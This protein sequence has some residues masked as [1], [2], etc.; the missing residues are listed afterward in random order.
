MVRNFKIC[1][2]SPNTI[3][4]LAQWYVDDVVKLHGALISVFFYRGIE[5]SSHLWRVAQSSLDTKM[6]LS[7]AF[8]PQT[9]KQTERVNQVLEDMLRA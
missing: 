1:I 4:E 8:H 9:D 3:E 2:F 7:T 5:F 6:R